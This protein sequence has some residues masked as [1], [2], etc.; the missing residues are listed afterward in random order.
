MQRS[1]Y[2]V[3]NRTDTFTSQ[4]I[5]AYG[6]ILDEST[7]LNVSLNPDNAGFCTP[8]ENCLIT[9]I[10]NVTTCNKSKQLTILIL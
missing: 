8:A 5:E 9:G 10:I 4:Q 3:Y 2:E 7:F 1:V 6:Y